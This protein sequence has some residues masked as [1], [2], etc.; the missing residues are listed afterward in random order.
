MISIFAVLAA[1]E[2]VVDYRFCWFENTTLVQWLTII[3]TE[4]Q[5]LSLRMASCESCLDIFMIEEFPA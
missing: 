3:K 2:S 4:I 1:I 5:Q